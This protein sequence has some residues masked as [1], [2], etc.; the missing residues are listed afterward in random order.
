MQDMTTTQSKDLFLSALQGQN[1][2]PKTLRAYG[3]DIKQFI[4]WVGKCR[5]DW[6]IPKRF[7]R[8]DIEGFR[9]FLGNAPKR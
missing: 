8:T 3:D 9:L 7:T 1:Y 6:D 2:S 4:E 5:V